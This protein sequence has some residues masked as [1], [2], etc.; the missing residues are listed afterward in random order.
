ML[1]MFLDEVKYFDAGIVKC[2]G[3]VVMQMTFR[4]KSSASVLATLPPVLRASKIDPMAAL[5]YE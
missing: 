2:T 5:R 4:A 1:P 3:N